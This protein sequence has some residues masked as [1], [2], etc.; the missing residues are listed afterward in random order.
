[1]N[2][3]Y[4]TKD[5]CF[6]TCLS[7]LLDIPVEEIPEIPD[8]NWHV[9]INEW[10]RPLGK[11]FLCFALPDDSNILKKFMGYHLIMGDSTRG[12]RHAV[13]GYNGEIYHDPFPLGDGILTGNIEYGVLVDTGEIKYGNNG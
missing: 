1:M 9:A 10:L 5:N 12:V 6:E 4:Q 2:L 8:K 7:I 13:L 11:W 3:K